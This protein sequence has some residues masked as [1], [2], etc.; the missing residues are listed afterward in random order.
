MLSGYGLTESLAVDK[1]TFLTK[2]PKRLIKILLPFCTVLLI[3]CML[4]KIIVTS[5][6]GIG[7]YGLFWFNVLL[8]FM[9]FYGLVA[10]LTDNNNTLFICMCVFNI[11]YAI[12]CQEFIL[13]YKEID[14]FG[15]GHQSLGFSAGIAFSL[16][17]EKV[18]AFIRKHC[19]I[20]TIVNGGIFICFSLLY[21]YICRKP[22]DI[23][24]LTY[25]QF[26]I[27]IIISFSFILL[28]IIFLQKYQVGNRVSSYIGSKMSLYIFASHG[29]YIY[30]T[31]SNIMENINSNSA[32]LFV[33]ILSLI[34]SFII[35]FIKR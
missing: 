4:E 8:L 12:L 35:S 34:T 15:W 16:Y 5:N 27:R 3:E 25:S 23:S 30:I 19:A 20:L 28:M 24:K 14:L 2:H 32:I 18:L 10:R 33:V 29:V 21:Y 13:S 1:N 6:S 11:V 26:F 17:K 7:G 31:Q 9:L 22:H